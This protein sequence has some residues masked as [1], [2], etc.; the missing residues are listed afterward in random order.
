MSLIGD[1]EAKIAASLFGGLLEV[2]HL[3]RRRRGPGPRVRLDPVGGSG[4]LDDVRFAAV[5]LV[6][7][8]DDE[9]DDPAQH[10]QADDPGQSVADHQASPL[11]PRLLLLA[12]LPGLAEPLPLF[13]PAIRHLRQASLL[14]G[15][16]PSRPYRH[17]GAPR[18][19]T[20]AERRARRGSPGPY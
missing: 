16:L 13:L 7:C 19:A 14:R 9:R 8:G 2:R 1:V 5:V 15:T 3:R 18:A 10:R 11:G 20:P 17:A 12:F 6:G 4:R